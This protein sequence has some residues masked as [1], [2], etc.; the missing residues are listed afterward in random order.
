MP[1]V[2]SFSPFFF[3]VFK[4]KHKK[5]LLLAFSSSTP[6]LKIIIFPPLFS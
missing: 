3:L 2:N 5:E 6:Y 4:Q 1:L